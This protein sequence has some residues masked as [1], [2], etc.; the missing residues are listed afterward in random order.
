MLSSLPPSVLN[1]LNSSPLP[2]PPALSPVGCA[3][4]PDDARVVVIVTFGPPLELELEPGPPRARSRG[5][6]REY[7]S[8]ERDPAVLAG[9]D[10]DDA[11][12]S[13]S[14]TS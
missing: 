8:G 9:G 5:D 14:L 12:E 10:D 4:L 1:L 7:A 2:A 13:T 6:P 11:D 3:P